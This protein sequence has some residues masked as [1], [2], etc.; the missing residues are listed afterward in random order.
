LVFG[1]DKL[2]PLTLSPSR[3][4]IHKAPPFARKISRA[5]PE[6]LA[7][8]ELCSLNFPRFLAS[9]ATLAFETSASALSF[10]FPTDMSPLRTRLKL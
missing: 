5:T 10:Y 6:A 7:P 4:G 9:S 2:A 1:L 8:V 3:F